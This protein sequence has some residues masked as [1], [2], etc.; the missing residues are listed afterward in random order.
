MNG[1]R[2]RG[3]FARHRPRGPNERV[4]EAPCL[5]GAHD[6]LRDEDSL[7]VEALERAE[8]Q[9]RSF[10]GRID[11]VVNGPGDGDNLNVGDLQLRGK[12]RGDRK[13]AACH[14]DDT[15]RLI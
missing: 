14:A 3:A 8:P 2:Q 1:A 9:D 6:V 4:D 7:L 5:A 11:P 10:L 12:G 15:R 13:S